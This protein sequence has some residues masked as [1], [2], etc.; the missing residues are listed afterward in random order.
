MCMTASRLAKRRT[1]NKC[2]TPN[3]VYERLLLACNILL[4]SG[5]PNAECNKMRCSMECEH[6]L[7]FYSE[8]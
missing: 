2:R 5:S 1:A 7:G 8:G 6:S 4:S 3:E